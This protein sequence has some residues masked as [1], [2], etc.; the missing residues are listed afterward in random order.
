VWETL[1]RVEEIEFFS[2]GQFFNRFTDKDSSGGIDFSGRNRG[3]NTCIIEEAPRISSQMFANQ[4]FFELGV[5][6]NF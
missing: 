6:G 4:K 2:V 5:N 1:F 3:R